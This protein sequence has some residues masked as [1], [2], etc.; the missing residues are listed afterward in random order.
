MNI[1]LIELFGLQ[2]WNNSSGKWEDLTAK[3][4]ESMLASLGPKKGHSIVLYNAGV[5]TGLDPVRTFKQAMDWKAFAVNDGTAITDGWSIF[6]DEAGLLISDA[7]SIRIRYYLRVT[8]M[9][10]GTPGVFS[11]NEMY[12]QIIKVSHPVDHIQFSS[13]G[14]AGPWAP[15]VTVSLPGISN[16]MVSDSDTLFSWLSN[17]ANWQAHLKLPNGEIRK[18]SV[19]NPTVKTGDSAEPEY[20]G[21]VAT[22]DFRLPMLQ[23]AQSGSYTLTISLLPNAQGSGGYHVFD[24]VYAWT[25]TITAMSPSMSD[26]LYLSFGTNTFMVIDFAQSL[27]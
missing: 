14:E 24:D 26:P 3:N 8:D 22:V 7:V 9:N 6:G 16:K 13:G 25:A 23:V 10:T 1:K 12:Y 4:S 19:T 18:Y 21:A 11:S 15:M 27:V 5:G 17:S 20:E 2:V